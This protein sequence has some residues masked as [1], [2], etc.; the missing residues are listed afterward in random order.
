MNDIELRHK[1]IW[2][3]KYR[4]IRFEIMKWRLGTIDDG[5]IVWNYYL[6]L[7]IEQIPSK[8]HKY[9]ILKGSYKKLSPDGQSHLFYN[10]SGTSYISDLD[11]HG[12]IT[13]YEKH[14]DGEGKLIGVKLGCDYAHYFDEVGGYPYDIDYVFME[15][16]QTIDKLYKLIPNMKV[17]CRWNGKFYDKSECEELPQGGY[18]ANENKSAWYKV[19]EP[20]RRN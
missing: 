11:W 7:P 20:I 15:T 9:F 12:D 4:D 5:H 13:F 3:G 14:L 10:Y 6:F 2:N 8:Y 18:L 17:S 19:R 16:K 1:D